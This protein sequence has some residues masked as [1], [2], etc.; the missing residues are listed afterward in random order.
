MCFLSNTTYY[1]NNAFVSL[2]FHFFHKGLFVKI[3]V[4]DYPEEKHF[5]PK[6]TALIREG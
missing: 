5:K 1:L 2:C 6:V 4:G 3:Q